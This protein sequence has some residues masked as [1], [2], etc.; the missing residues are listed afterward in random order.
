M[1]DFNDQYGFFDKLLHRFAFNTKNM[2]LNLAQSETEQYQQQ[3]DQIK[4]ERPVFITGLPRAGTTILLDVFLSLIH[5]LWFSNIAIA[6][7]NFILFY[8]I[9]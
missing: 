5:S 1:A 4:I 8:L 9:V 2:Q 7:F 6:S 3:L